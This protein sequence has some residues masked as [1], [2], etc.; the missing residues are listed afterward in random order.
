[1]SQENK[2]FW[3]SFTADKGRVFTMS[4][5]SLF[6][7]GGVLMMVLSGVSALTLGWTLF[8]L[9]ID[10]LIFYDAWKKWENESP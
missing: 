5:I 4:I 2:T 3:K 6:L 1:M 7:L 10:I 9:G 8:F